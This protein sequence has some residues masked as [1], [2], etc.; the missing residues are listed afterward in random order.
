VTAGVLGRDVPDLGHPGGPL[1]ETRTRV[2]R[3]PLFGI[4]AGQLVATEVAAAAVL[5]GAVGGTVTLAV[6]VALAVVL[7]ALTWLRMRG[8]WAFEWLAT[9]LRFAGRRHAIRVDTAPT[10]LLNFVAPGS[11]VVPTELGGD[12][13]AMVVDGL[14]LTAV[15]E[16][17][18]PTGPLVEDAHVL[19][20]PA[21]L[22][23]APTA[24]HPPCRIQLVLTGVPAPAVRAGAGTPANSYRQ[25]TEG[26][27]LGHSR[28]LLAVRVLRD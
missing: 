21:A 18:D 20:S 23:P 3:G 4:R 12:T 22:L 13:A 28:A 6:A 11:R 24:E 1:P 10:A 5:A 17:G 26:R 8:R 19:P 7:V 16:L 25:L 15:L 2:R 14:G 9:A 27:L